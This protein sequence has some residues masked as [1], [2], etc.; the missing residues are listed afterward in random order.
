MS[1]IKFAERFE[2]AGGARINEMFWIASSYEVS[3]L[4]E[5]LSN[6][7]PEDF[8]KMFPKVG[9]LSMYERWREDEGLAQALTE[10]GYW[11]L[12]AEVHV[13][14]CDN[15]R[16]DDEGEPRSWSVHPGISTIVH[17]YGETL[18]QLMV[19]IEKQYKQLFK[20]WVAKEKKK[21]SKR[22]SKK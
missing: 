12:V 3:D 14:Q 7:E 18:N 13:P 9:S 4:G 15:F 17:A 5:L 19:S 16:F 10:Y 21:A 2:Q 22:P 8:M 6:I 20:E 11:G 1:N